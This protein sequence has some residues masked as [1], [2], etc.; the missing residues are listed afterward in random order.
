[1]AVVNRGFEGRGGSDD[2]RLPPGQHLTD[3]FP[4]LSASVTP[5][6]PKDKWELTVTS[7]TGVRRRWSWHDL[8]AI[9]SESFVADTHCVTRWSKLGHSLAR[10]LR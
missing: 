4:V 3:D 2:H 9:P 8:M 6:I 1:M 10:G 5:L 7:E